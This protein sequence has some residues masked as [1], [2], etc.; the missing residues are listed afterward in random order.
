M[1][2]CNDISL[3]EIQTVARRK[4]IVYTTAFN[5]CHATQDGF[6]IADAHVGKELGT[7]YDRLEDHAKQ[8][9]P[10]LTSEISVPGRAEA[11]MREAILE[12]QVHRFKQFYSF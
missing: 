1:M 4:D 3:D 8:A 7:R 10:K 12:A 11:L 5:R 9:L 2:F 6:L